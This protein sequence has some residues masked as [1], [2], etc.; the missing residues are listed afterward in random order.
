MFTGSS[1]RIKIILSVKILKFVLLQ[2]NT[3]YLPVPLFPLIPTYIGYRYFIN[4][5]HVV[6][7][8][9]F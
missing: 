6:K 8:I 9:K 4:T 2:T 1:F 5:V 7:K 3:K